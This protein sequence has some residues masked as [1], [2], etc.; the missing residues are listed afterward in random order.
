MRARCRLEAPNEASGAVAMRKR[1]DVG[2]QCK[3]IFCLVAGAKLVA[4]E[5]GL[6]KIAL[7]GAATRLASGCASF[8]RSCDAGV[9]MRVAAHH[10][11]THLRGEGED[12]DTQKVSAL[13]RWAVI[14]SY[15]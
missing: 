11:P 5:G 10:V 4:A 1:M 2:L 14:S 12:S 15:S 8:V 6:E 13:H 7:M 3:G 9:R